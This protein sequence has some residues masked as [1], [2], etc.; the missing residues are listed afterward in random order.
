MEVHNS[1]LKVVADN[2]EEAPLV[3]LEAILN[4]GG[5]SWVSVGRESAKT[6]GVGSAGESCD[7]YTAFFCGAILAAL[8][9][10][11]AASIALE[12]IAN[13]N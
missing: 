12:N 4:E 2:D 13:Q 8:R 5:D 7:T 10:F 6:V 3:L 1:I 11:L 9:S